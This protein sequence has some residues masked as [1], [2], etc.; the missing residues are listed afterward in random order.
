[1]PCPSPST[2][3]MVVLAALSSRPPGSSLLSAASS[4]SAVYGASI[5]ERQSASEPLLSSVSVEAP[6][7]G[8][9]SSG[10]ECATAPLLAMIWLR[11]RPDMIRSTKRGEVMS[12]DSSRG[13]GPAYVPFWSVRRTSAPASSRVEDGWVTLTD[14]TGRYLATHPDDSSHDKK[15]ER[16]Q[17]VVVS[18]SET[19]GCKWRLARVRVNHSMSMTLESSAGLRLDAGWYRG[20]HCVDA[21]RRHR[22]WPGLVL[23]IHYKT[24]LFDP[25]MPWR[26]FS[27]SLD[28]SD[29]LPSTSSVH[30][31]SLDI[32]QP[33]TLLTAMPDTSL[34]ITASRMA[35]VE[36]QLVR[37]AHFADI[38][39]LRSPTTGLHLTADHAPA[40]LAVLMAPKCE[41]SRWRLRVLSG[42]EAET[43]ATLQSVTTE[44]Y[45]QAKPRWLA[46]REEWVSCVDKLGRATKLTVCSVEAVTAHPWSTMG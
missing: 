36:W 12:L 33:D 46:G 10:S 27:L 32:Y 35:G 34:Q 28:Q 17:R 8:S 39:Y 43:G 31:M 2:L 16:R 14:P 3:S 44:W 37:S 19:D 9:V 20:V 25:R 38:V 21:A 45:L 18:G 23:P 11:T 41:G 24:S 1:M 29:E 13:F 22:Q 42:S 26:A 40:T 30:V 6:C 4:S 15:G 7:Q 5:A